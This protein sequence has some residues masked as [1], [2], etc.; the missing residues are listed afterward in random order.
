MKRRHFLALS[1]ATALSP[2]FRLNASPQP[3]WSLS[4]PLPIQTQ[5]IYACVHK[6]KLYFAGGIASKLGVPYFSNECYGFDSQ[7]KKWISETSLPENLHHAALV[8]N[9]H[10]LYQIGGFNG[11]YTHVWRMRSSCYRL[12]NDQWIPTA[13]LPKP[14]AE[15]VVSAAPDG[16]IHIVSGQSPKATANRLRS[17]HSEVNRHLRWDTSTN[18][19][20]DAAPIPTP[21]NSASGGWINNQMIVAGGRTSR[22]NLSTTEIYDKNEDR[23]R[24]LAPLPKPQ[25]GTASVVVGSNLIILGGEIFIPNA[26]VFANVWRYSLDS[27]KWHALPDL[28]IARHGLGAG[29]IGK[30][31]YAI[32]GATEPSGNGT[33]NINEVLNLENLF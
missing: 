13:E 23:W 26:G 8:S 25:A 6:E 11:G 33:S 31:L 27:D 30:K 24:Q 3:G 12:E 7:H 16:A 15:G 1:T 28:G 19:W 14:Q 18:R 17:D 22:G 4:T 2:S 32:G 5:E 29:L 9:G 10:G 20:E 21:R